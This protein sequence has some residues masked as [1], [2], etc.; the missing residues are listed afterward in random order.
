MNKVSIA[1]IFASFVLASVVVISF[2]MEMFTTEM[3][4]FSNNTITRL[5]PDEMFDSRPLGF[6]QVVIAPPGQTIYI[7]GQGAFDKDLQI[8]GD[9]MEEQIDVAFKN[10]KSALEASGAKP[11]H[12]VQIV[13]LMVDYDE[14]YLSLV[15]KERL[16]FFGNDNLPASTLIPVP[17]LA[18]DGM[19]FEIQ[20]TAVIPLNNPWVKIGTTN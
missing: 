9:T 14:S 8:V 4:N 18:I 10:V 6:S 5:Q 11:E 13:M 7:A 20:V 2:T 15:Q 16:E 1:I 19:L 17:S 12:V 3:E